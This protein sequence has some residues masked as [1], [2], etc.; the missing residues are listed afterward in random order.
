MPE[1]RL[2]FS[3]GAVFDPVS[4]AEVMARAAEIMG[5]EGDRIIL[6]EISRDTGDQARLV[7]KIVGDERFILVTSASH[8]P[9]SMVLFRKSGMEPIP[10]PTDYRVPRCHQPSQD[11]N[12]LS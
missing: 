8:M 12:D 6:E 7:Q 3:G 2:V 11:G 9:R 4:E 5:V 10:A 1:S